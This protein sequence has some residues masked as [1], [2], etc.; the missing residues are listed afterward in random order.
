MHLFNY[1]TIRL[2]AVPM[3]LPQF[4][5]GLMFVAVGLGFAWGATE[6]SFGTSARPGPGYFPFGLGILMAVLGGAVLGAMREL[7]GSSEDYHAALAAP[8]IPDDAT[9]L[10]RKAAVMAAMRAEH[11]ALK[12]R[13]DRLEKLSEAAAERDLR[14]LQARLKAAVVIDPAQHDLTE[15][16]FGLCV[17]VADADGLLAKAREA[18][19]RVPRS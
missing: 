8:V 3:V 16:A 1:P 7:G 12:A 19:L 17:T 15:V 5:S 9:K 13:P 6:Y 10:Q 2:A 14:W 4:W 11:A 18:G